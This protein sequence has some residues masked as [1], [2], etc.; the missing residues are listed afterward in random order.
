MI[1]LFIRIGCILPTKYCFIKAAILIPGHFLNIPS[2][3][4]FLE[5]FYFLEKMRL[6]GSE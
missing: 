2:L 1:I 5:T 6:H 3:D 4:K